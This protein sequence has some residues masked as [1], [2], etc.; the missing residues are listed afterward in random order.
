[1]CACAYALGWGICVCTG[2]WWSRRQ[3]PEGPSIFLREY[4]QARNERQ[5]PELDLRF[6]GPS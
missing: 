2:V 1:M 6:L 4:S 3:G 5:Q